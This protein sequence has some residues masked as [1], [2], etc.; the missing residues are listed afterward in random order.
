VV[1]LVG[2]SGVAAAAVAWMARG[3]PV[4][5]PV[6]V[7]WSIGAGLAAGVGIAALYRG[8]ATGR[9]AIV[10]PVTG[11]LAAIVPVGVGFGLQG[12]PA[13][14]VLA[15]IGL[16]FVAVLLVSRV[17][18]VSGEPAGV[19]LAVIA[20]VG[21][22]LFNV[23]IANVTEGLLFGPL[24][25]VRL[26]EAGLIG[27]V[28]LATRQ[29]WRVPSP[30][31][32]PVALIGLLDATGNAAFI[33]AEQAG[34]LDVASVLSSLYPVTTLVLAAVVLRERVTR[35]HGAGIAAALGA[36]ALIAAGST[37]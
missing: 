2:I 32:A 24:T 19:G 30:L 8:L 3:E 36:I 1:F 37:G 33:A 5:G 9:M 12:L 22:G 10:A 28:V 29:A 25:V 34:R 15:G 23:F 17:P 13:P 20:G 27:I 11:L 14:T 35:L 7:A 4:P 31:L 6:D 18:G 16:A 21:L 26:A